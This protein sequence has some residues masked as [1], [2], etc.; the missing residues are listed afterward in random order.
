[1]SRSAKIG[2]AVA[3]I[4]V[5]GVAAVPWAERVITRRYERRIVQAVK[6]RHGG[7]LTLEDFHVGILTS[8]ASVRSFRYE[9]PPGA[10][11]RVV[12]TGGATSV[13][14]EALSFDPDPV[15]LREVRLEKPELTITR[16]A[17]GDW[18]RGVPGVARDLLEVG[19]ARAKRALGIP[20]VEIHRPA[21]PPG[22]PVELRERQRGLVIGSLVISD[23]R[24]SYVD[25]RF[26]DTPLRL[27]L[28]SFSFQGQ[29]I[30]GADLWRA[31]LTSEADGTLEIGTQR[32]DIKATTRTVAGEDRKLWT[33]EA[34]GIDLPLIAGPLLR[35]LLVEVKGGTLDVRL[36]HAFDLSVSERS[37]IVVDWNLEGRGVD[38][39]VLPSERLPMLQAPA[40]RLQ[41]WVAAREGRV[42][43]AFS[44]E[45][46]PDLALLGKDA[47]SVIESVG[48]LT[49]DA[50][51]RQIL[52]AT[53]ISWLASG[54]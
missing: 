47:G 9:D 6:E 34:L 37:T 26:S 46:A 38:L 40:E 22:A 13:D 45:A 21:E 20:D 30:S 18:D 35:P 36:S 42:S 39:A 43:L 16:T 31:F 48:R 8:R 11:Y 24:V 23:A 44:V 50:F 3:G 17:R 54:S 27:T 2:A 5:I 52:E 49:F 4:M 33:L 53:G 51:K 1:M 14:V 25:D 7:T 28:R 19:L 32:V 10:P 15:R 29:D 12:F 41:A